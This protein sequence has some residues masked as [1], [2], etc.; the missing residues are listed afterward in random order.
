MKSPAEEVYFAVLAEVMRQKDGINALP[1]LEGVTFI[2]RMNRGKAVRVLFRTESQGPV[3][4]TG[5]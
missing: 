2:V 1:D 4:E 5:S 3:R